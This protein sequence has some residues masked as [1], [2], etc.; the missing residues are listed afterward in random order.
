MDS[1]LSL[2]AAA[3]LCSLY[4]AI[5]VDSDGE[6]GAKNVAFGASTGPSSC[7]SDCLSWTYF[8]AHPTF[9]TSH[10]NGPVL[11]LILN[12]FVSSRAWKALSLQY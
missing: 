1:H 5:R 2:W 9:P 12:L 11:Y 8:F 6:W 3:L 7:P 10:R 4:I